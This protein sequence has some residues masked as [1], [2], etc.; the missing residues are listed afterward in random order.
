MSKTNKTLVTFI[1]CSIIIN[2][3]FA[4]SAVLLSVFGYKQP[5]IALFITFF[6][7][8]YHVDIRIIIGAIVSCFKSKINVDKALFIV[9]K[10]EFHLLVFFKVKHWKDRFATLHKDQFVFEKNDIVSL[11]KNNINAE[12]VHHIC[13]F[14]GFIAI[15]LGY[16]ISPDE[17]L[18]YVIT[19][20]LASFLLDLPPIMIQRYNRYRLQNIKNM[21]RNKCVSR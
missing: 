9:S 14:V 19:S 11:L 13:F 21:Q 8:A 6:M 7:F 4:I 2:A 15:A 1:I 5:Y 16:L 17:L 3:L 20:A 18:V 10:R 12:I